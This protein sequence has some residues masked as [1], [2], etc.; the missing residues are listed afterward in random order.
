MIKVYFILFLVFGFFKSLKA[1]IHPC[2]ANFKFNRISKNGI[3]LSSTNPNVSTIA[4]QFE[5][6]DSFVDGLALIKL[7]G[8]YGYIDKSGKLV[9]KPQFGEAYSFSEDLALVKIQGSYGYIDR[10][11]NLVIQTQFEH[12]GF[13][14]KV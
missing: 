5:E 11:G 3:Y 10:N 6:A 1:E 2:T 12:S 13:F 9:I 14:R 8:K 7:G 4:V